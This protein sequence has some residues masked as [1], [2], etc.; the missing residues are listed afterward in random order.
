MSS[1]KDSVV[2]FQEK[3]GEM[4]ETDFFE[5]LKPQGESKVINM[6][7][8]SFPQTGT[9]IRFK[10]KE[11][12]Y[13]SSEFLDLESF[14][15]TDK[16]ESNKIAKETNFRSNCSSHFDEYL[17]TCSKSIISMNSSLSS[18]ESITFED[19][20]DC[21]LQGNQN[22][23]VKDENNI[24]SNEP[25]NTNVKVC[26]ENEI[27]NDELGREF[28]AD[29][30]HYHTRTGFLSSL[31]NRF[32]NLEES[33]SLSKLDSISGIKTFLLGKI[34]QNNIKSELNTS[35]YVFSNP[36]LE[37]G[38]VYFANS[39]DGYDSQRSESDTSEES[40]RYPSFCLDD[41]NQKEI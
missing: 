31:S 26:T 3:I 14:S 37:D 36:K 23:T 38:H 28:S 17:D 33:L 22:T 13:N 2:S 25:S 11:S 9:I 41:T 1:L 16:G 4:E 30:T 24:N 40:V 6:K 32:W 10:S 39:R 7:D 35:N 34:G 20:N 29:L 27:F 12:M 15:E 21:E 8:S 19:N 5:K 18:V